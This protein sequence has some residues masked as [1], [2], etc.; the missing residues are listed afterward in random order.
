ML[1]SRCDTYLRSS[2]IA[3]EEDL[4]RACEDFDEDKLEEL[5]KSNQLNF[6]QQQVNRIGKNLQVSMPRGLVLL[7]ERRAGASG[8]R[9]RV[10]ECVGMEG[11]WHGSDLAPGKPVAAS[12][13]QP[14][15]G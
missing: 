4:V 8:E 9:R 11:S 15:S 3:L 12:L 7:G 6:V 14:P 10:G 5:K 1:L 2:E 13:M